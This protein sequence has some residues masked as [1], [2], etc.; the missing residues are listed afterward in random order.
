MSEE[1]NSWISRINPIDL[2]VIIILLFAVGSYIYKPR[3]STYGGNQMYS[4]IQDHQRL[5][6]RGFIVEGTVEGTF[7]WDGSQFSE[8]G[9]LLPST[10]GRLRLRKPDGETVVIGGER[11]Y[12]ED[13]AASS[14]QI[15]PVDDYLAVFYI[16]P[17]SF[18][19]YSDLASYLE[20]LKSDLKADH[21]Y[22]DLE[23]AVDSEMTPSER[24]MVVNQLNSLYLMRDRYLSRAESTGFVINIVKGEVS[25]IGMLKIDEGRVST[26]R[27]RAYAGYHETPPSVIPS[28]SVIVSAS[29]LL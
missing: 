25:E 14:I 27:I 9:I 15:N 28:D 23:V 20:S 17:L 7:L 12:I 21:L 18:E 19:Q 22:L 5:D 24:E 13:V 8:K 4:A 2:L 6:S 16:E 26:N 10:S 3:T 11:A 1:K 29:E